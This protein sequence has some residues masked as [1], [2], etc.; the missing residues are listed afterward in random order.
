MPE[1]EPDLLAVDIVQQ[2]LDARHQQVA[3]AAFWAT[4]VSFP[5]SLPQAWLERR[6]E[7]CN[8]LKYD[9]I[10]AFN[11]ENL[12]LSPDHRQ[13]PDSTKKLAR[14]QNISNLCQSISVVARPA[15]KSVLNVYQSERF[16][17]SARVASCSLQS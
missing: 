14:M 5:S 6:L 15:M 13:S 8:P 11:I 10:A 1:A 7:V 3:C 16:S 17:T 4:T 2:V 9:A 12:Q